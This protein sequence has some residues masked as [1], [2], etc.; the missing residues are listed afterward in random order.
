MNL[1]NIFNSLDL[2]RVDDET[3]DK[4]SS[5]RDMISKAG[6]FGVK[7]AVASLPMVFSMMPKI[8]N[9]QTQSTVDVFNFALTLEYLESEFYNKGISISGLIPPTYRE[10][11]TTIANHEVEH[12]NFLKGALGA[13]AVAKPTFDFTAGGTFSQAFSNYGTFLVL[14]QSFEDTGVRAY[15]GQAGNIT[16]GNLLTAAL[17]IH[18][19]EARHASQLRRLNG[20][21]G[22]ISVEGGVA[23]GAVSQVDAVY[24]GENNTTQLGVDV[25]TI[26]SGVSIGQAR[27]S[28]DEPL[29]RDQVL[30]IVAP[31]IK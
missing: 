26:N 17:Q 13:S 16:E 23:N 12:V 3:Y 25:S 6:K 5:R 31:F 18:S 21:K 4:L 8:V 11:F 28:F 19:V 2:S 22:W 10:V 9:A 20:Q 15:K 1:I 27:E 14:A 7:A 29:T 30:A 24:A